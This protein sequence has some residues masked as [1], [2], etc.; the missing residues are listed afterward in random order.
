MKEGSSLPDFATCISRCLHVICM[1]PVRTSNGPQG[2]GVLTAAAGCTNNPFES[3]ARIRTV[4][5]AGISELFFV[6]HA[7]PRVSAADS[8]PMAQPQA[9][10]L[11]TCPLTLGAAG[12]PDFRIFTAVG[13][14]GRMD[15][16][17]DVAHSRWIMSRTLSRKSCSAILVVSL[18][19]AFF[20][21]MPGS[22]K[23]KILP[24]SRSDI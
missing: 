1:S 9:H 21:D 24:G 17:L 15:V 6:L 18:S 10:H 8:A 14:V 13:A 20:I 23:S 2:S 7:C 3:K 5:K 4:S 11:S 16:R 22:F 12:R 19:S